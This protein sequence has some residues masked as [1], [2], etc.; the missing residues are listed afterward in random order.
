MKKPSLDGFFVSAIQ[1]PSPQPSPRGRGGRPRCLASD[2][3][4]KDFIDYGFGTTSF[5]SITD[6]VE[7]FQ[8]DVTSKH[9][10]ISP[11]YPRETASDLQP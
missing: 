8:V 10:P 9:P 5:T 1:E 2:I 7:H 4:L 3:D 6:S 11:F